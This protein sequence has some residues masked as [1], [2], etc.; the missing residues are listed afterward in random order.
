MVFLDMNYPYTTEF[1]SNALNASECLLTT[2]ILIRIRAEHASTI[3][4]VKSGYAVNCKIL[5]NVTQFCGFKS[6]M[7]VFYA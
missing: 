6:S 4:Y 3:R 7:P 1:T 5:I 2:V